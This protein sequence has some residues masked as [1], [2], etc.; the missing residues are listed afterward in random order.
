VALGYSS[1]CAAPISV[2]EELWG[3]IAIGRIGG[4]AFDEQTEERLGE[5]GRLAGFAVAN[6]D[7]RERLEREALED[8]LT[9]L[10]NLRQFHD[11]LGHA[12]WHAERRDAPLALCMLDLD[13]FKQANDTHGHPTGDAVLR[14]VASRLS[15]T[16]RRGELLARIGGDEFALLMPDTPREQALTAGERLRALVAA[17]PLIRGVSLTASVGIANRGDARSADELVRLADGALY[18]A[19]QEGRDRAVAY[20]AR[21]VHDLSHVERTQRLV[22]AQALAGLRA[23]ARAVDAKDAATWAHSERVA[24]L[25]AH[26]ARARGWPE[27]DVELLHEA[28]LIHDVGKIG[29]PDGILLKPGRLNAAEYDVIKGHAELGARIAGEVLDDRQVAWLRGHHERFDGS[30]YP[31]GIA[32]DE[33]PEGAALLALADAWDAMT[34]AR[35]YDEPRSAEDALAECHAQSGRQFAPLAVDALERTRRR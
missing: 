24:A 27:E 26:L 8:P 28:G 25:A 14:A 30:G 35:V 23:L 34:G 1:F 2:D 16:V 15:P 9:D 22:H 19:K 5:Y 6:A 18:W 31:D 20:D 29:V 33:I 10:P 3:A 7:R 17:S 12:W 21:V 4:A 11:R 13:G 32:G